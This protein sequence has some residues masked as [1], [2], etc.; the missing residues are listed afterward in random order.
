MIINTT[1]LLKEI[2]EDMEQFNSS[3]LP[4]NKATEIKM[5]SSLYQVLLERFYTTG[6]GVCTMYSLKVE[7][8]DSIRRFEI[9]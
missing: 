4:E 7:I 3:H 6:Y 2:L 1:S 9:A 8:N 5:H